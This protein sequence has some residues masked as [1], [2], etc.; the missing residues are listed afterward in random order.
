VKYR[1]IKGEILM[2]PRHNVGLRS[3]VPTSLIHFMYTTHMRGM[4]LVAQLSTKYS[5]FETISDGIGILF[6]YPIGHKYG[7]WMDFK[8]TRLVENLECNL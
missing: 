1:A 7:E 8:I 3:N 4:D 2:L 5:M 6:I